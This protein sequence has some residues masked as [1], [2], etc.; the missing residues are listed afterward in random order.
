M[1]GAILTNGKPTHFPK[2]TMQLIFSS[3]K[4]THLPNAILQ[5]T[6]TL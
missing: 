6:F 4:L 1:V 2:L 3:H 5:R